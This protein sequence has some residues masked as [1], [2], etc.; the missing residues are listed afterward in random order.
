MPVTRGDNGALAVLRRAVAPLG[1]FLV[2]LAIWSAVAAFGA[3][4]DSIFPSP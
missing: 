3:F 2:V 1:S 4:P